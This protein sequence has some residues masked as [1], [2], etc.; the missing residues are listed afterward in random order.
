MIQRI[1]DNEPGMLE[2]VASGKLTDFEYQSVL[3]PQVENAIQESGKINVLWK[4]DNFD[5]WELHAAW[6]EFLLALKTRDTIERI[7][8]V[9]DKPWQKKLVTYLKPLT[10]AEVQ[11]Y[12]SDRSEEAQ[13]WLKHSDEV[14][15]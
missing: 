2:F 5:G 4:M 14:K 6:D 8:L 9:G 1:Y 7:A 10:H 12:D 15:H 13:D 3:I 11:Y